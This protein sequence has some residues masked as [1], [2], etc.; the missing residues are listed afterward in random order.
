LVGLIAVDAAGTRLGEVTGVHH[1]PTQDLLVLI[2]DA[3]ERLV[4][5]VLELVPEVDVP[6]GRVV[7]NPIPGLLTEAPDAD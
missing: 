5:F 6:G 2:T 7:I 1:N 4:P 3:G